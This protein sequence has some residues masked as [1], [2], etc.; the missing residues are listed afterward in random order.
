[1]L[2]YD[3]AGNVTAYDRTTGDDRYIA[4][5]ARNLPTA[6]T[7]SASAGA[8]MPTARETFRYGPSSSRYHRKSSWQDGSAQRSEETLYAGG[9]EELRFAGANT[10]TVIQKAQMTDNQ[11]VTPTKPADHGKIQPESPEP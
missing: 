10:A 3:L 1:M 2:A 6:V 11:R 7:E 9:F 5:D 4:R 8:A